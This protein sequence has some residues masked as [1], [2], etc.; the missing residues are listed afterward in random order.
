MAV[1]SVEAALLHA[2]RARVLALEEELS[3]PFCAGDPQRQQLEQ[4]L[5]MERNALADRLR[6]LEHLEKV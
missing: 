1:G 4:R 5:A 6:H 3:R 2:H